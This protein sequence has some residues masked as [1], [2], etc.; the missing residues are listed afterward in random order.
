ML[1][2]IFTLTAC[3]EEKILPPA[4]YGEEVGSVLLANEYT[5]DE[6]KEA[7][8]Y[9]AQLKIGN[10]VSENLTTN[11]TMFEAEVVKVYK[12]PDGKELPDDIIFIQLASSKRIFANIPLMTYG[13]EIFVF[14]SD[15]DYSGVDNAYYSIGA[16]STV[17]YVVNDSSGETYAV[18]RF[19]M[20]GPT[21]DIAN[22][23]VDDV[24][25]DDI[26]ACAIKSDDVFSKI[27][28]PYC[29]IFNF[30]DLCT[31]LFG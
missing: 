21:T 29:Y 24:K 6:A 17:L 20:L 28:T 16:F 1:L 3:G 12:S 25:C 5:F 2:L 8:D 15:A 7:A 18:D 26:I 30:D 4:R 22:Y 27:I 9:I 23:A 19:T 13:N 11:E 31:E 10:W 14:L